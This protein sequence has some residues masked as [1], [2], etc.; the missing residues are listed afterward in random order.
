VTQ[1]IGD[2]SHPFNDR[3]VALEMLRSIA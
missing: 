1:T 3:E 2:E